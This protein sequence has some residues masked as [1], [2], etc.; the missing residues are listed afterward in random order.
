MKLKSIQIDGMHNASS[1]KYELSDVNYFY[2]KNGAGKSTIL[3]AIQ[4]AV[5][6][7]VPGNK[8]QN[9]AIMKHGKGRM[10]SVSAVFD[11]NGKSVSVE[12]SYMKKGST[13]QSSLDT[14]PEEYPVE[15]ILGDIEL[16]VCN[17][18]EFLAMSSNAQKAWFLKMMPSSE[19]KFKWTD[20]F[21]KSAE[22]ILTEDKLSEFLEEFNL[23]EYPTTID[24]CNQL[25]AVIKQKT[26]LLNA[27]LKDL[28]GAI[29]SSIMYDDIECSDYDA[30]IE[31]HKKAAQSDS[32]R[33][34]ELKSLIHS[35]DTRK[36]ILKSYEFAKVRMKEAESVFS[37]YKEDKKFVTEADL[38]RYKQLEAEK[39][40]IKEDINNNKLETSRLKGIIDNPGVCPYL[41]TSCDDLKSFV[42]TNKKKYES[43]QKAIDKANIRLS[44]IE[45]EQSDISKLVEEQSEYD[46]KKSNAESIYQSAVN[47]V[48]S[49]EALIST[50]DENDSDIDSLTEDLK[51]VEE[52]WDRHNEMIAKLS[53]N[54]KY[55]ELINSIESK[56]YLYEQQIQCCKI[57]DKLTGPNGKPSE[58]AVKPFEEFE[59]KL[60]EYIHKVFP[61]TFS[62]KFN[63][64]DKANSFEFGV[65]NEDK[66]I[67]F[68][69]L[70]S[71]EKCA[72]MICLLSCIVEMSDAKWKCIILDDVFDHLDDE[73][74][75]QVFSV[76]NTFSK[77][78]QFILA[79][80]K[81]P[82]KSVIKNS[83][84]VKA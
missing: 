46:R 54:K 6:G 48:S 63:I 24:G 43:I 68:E 45:A 19:S 10:M 58:L 38:E 82:C 14:N 30:E 31:D 52:S 60:T 62:A 71:G 23:K 7:Y 15:S 70:S 3:Q 44:E 21:K 4:L 47:S 50:I 11:D 79:S 18:N 35:Y 64:S 72:Y 20:E 42:E 26:S 57:W 51:L 56:K 22:A 73:R 40:E 28:T 83:I 59:K 84:E 16:P 2:G 25:N 55:E 81:A 74:M 76:I 78:I 9:A 34:S 75:E 33:V 17:F 53:A 12:R 69:A 39:D 61:S 27:L 49:A 13:V 1:K 37:E 36:Q 5:L 80:V 41:K 32:E 66:F 65:M 29:N 67:S 77:S 8:K